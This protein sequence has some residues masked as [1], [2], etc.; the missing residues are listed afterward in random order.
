MTSSSS[1]ASAGNW[2][3][4]S[5]TGIWG[6]LAPETGFNG[7]GDNAGQLST[8]WTTH[9][10]QQTIS[11]I[12]NF[13]AF[14]LNCSVNE[15]TADLRPFS[16]SDYKQIGISL[17]L[18][19]ALGFGGT[20]TTNFSLYSGISWFGASSERIVYSGDAKYGLTP[21]THIYMQLI[22]R[23]N[24]T[25]EYSLSVMD[26]GGY[27]T[28]PNGTVYQGFYAFFNQTINVNDGFFDN[29]IFPILTVTHAGSGHFQFNIYGED[30]NNGEYPEFLGGLDI[31][32]AKETIIESLG[33]LSD[34]YGFF[35]TLWG[36]IT[37]MVMFAIALIQGFWPI[38]PILIIFYLL[39]MF[40]TSYERGG[41]VAIGDTV[42]KLYNGLIQTAT[43]IIDAIKMITDI[44]MGGVRW[45]IGLF[46]LII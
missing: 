25:L 43:M 22:R 8:F 45:L 24:T 17:K 37:G 29:E 11:G 13:T 30:Y 2:T 42:Y 3:S 46:G 32:E 36:I 16:F 40:W 14:T 12:A 41:F 5:L 1:F 9:P 27:T 26:K 38:F 15:F 39:D 4:P 21:P 19:S 34:I 18:A 35:A 31:A 20:M 33:F 28:L 44:V 10:D 6:P 23:S 7:T